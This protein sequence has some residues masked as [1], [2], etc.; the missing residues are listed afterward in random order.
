MTGD[1]REVAAGRRLT[2]SGRSRAYLDGSVASAAAL[3]AATTGV[4]EIVAQHDQLAITR[5]SEVRAA[6]DQTLD[7]R[8]KACLADYATAWAEYRRLLADQKT[9]GGDRPSLERER[10]LLHHQIS[11]I[12]GAGFEPGADVELETRLSRLRNAETLRLHVNAASEAL[13]RGRDDLGASV[14]E[15]RKAAAYDPDLQT[16]LGEL[17]AMED[18]MGGIAIRLGASLDDLQSEEGDLQ[19]S[20][21]RLRALNDLR[22]KY[23]PRLDDVHAFAAA[24]K[25]RLDDLDDLLTRADTLDEQLD[26]VRGRLDTV[27]AALME[28]R[29]RAAGT[30]AV[31]AEHH[32]RELG[33]KD[34]IV[35]PVVG[36]GEP[37]A[38]GT[39]SV[40]L[41]F[42]SDRRLKPG[43][44][45]KVA[46]G[47]EFESSRPCIATRRGG[48]GHRDARLRR[49]R[50]RRGWCHGL[51]G[52]AQARSAGRASTGPVRDPPSAGGGVR[53]SALRRDANRQ[54]GECGGG[55]RRYEGSRS[56]AACW[57]VCPTPNGAGSCRGA[58]R[59]GSSGTNI[60]EPHTS[61]LSGPYSGHGTHPHPTRR[62]GVH[63]HPRSTRA[64]ECTL[65]GS[66]G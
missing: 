15:I 39:D 37:S 44:I 59:S 53:R 29:V 55:G 11:E 8:G 32:L 43:E 12:E 50:C 34:P 20:E 25:E 64:S 54:W 51:G 10:D 57:P 58:G 2:A 22:R 49:D 31:T 18:G 27:G 35:A 63:D 36:A 7:P 65:D 47:G 13:D 40:E 23:G 1:G 52:R 60:A 17:E 42:A 56:S 30:L 19:A 45:G 26:E 3:D 41:R 33:F 24:A 6:I 48:R 46:S 66:H 14:A 5:P 4:V 9:I 62:A 21:E 61:R 28:S 16:A 38:S